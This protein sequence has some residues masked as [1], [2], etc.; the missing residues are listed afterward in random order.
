MPRKHRQVRS[1][2][3][4]AAKGQGLSSRVAVLKWPFP[5]SR[6]GPEAAGKEEGRGTKGRP[7]PLQIS[8]Q[9]GQDWRK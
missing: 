5:S 4:W 1:E 2:G 9:A 6:V 3:S 8:Q 7:A